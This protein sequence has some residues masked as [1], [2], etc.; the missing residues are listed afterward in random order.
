VGLNVFLKYNI[1]TVL[2][3]ILLHELNDHHTLISIQIGYLLAIPKLD[4]METDEDFV[5]P[6]LEFVVS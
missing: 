4:S 5:I 1:I 2:C 3:N 6:G